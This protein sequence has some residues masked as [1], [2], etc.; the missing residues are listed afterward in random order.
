MVA[1]GLV[2]TSVVSL[3]GDRDYRLT[4]PP[5]IFA[6]PGAEMNV[7]FANTVLVNPGREDEIRFQAECAVG[8]ADAEK[9]TLNA[10]EAEVGDRRFVL[11]VLDSGSGKVL[12]EAESVVR[13]VPGN[14]GV[15]RMLVCS[16]SAIA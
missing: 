9:W 14:A 16:S 4:L 12:E 5:V 15:G 10:N 8:T 7:F 6:V 13:V 11:R 3:A 2:L 1:F